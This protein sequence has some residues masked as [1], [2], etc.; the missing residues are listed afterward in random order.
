MQGGGGGGRPVYSGGIKFQALQ[1]H[2]KTAIYGILAYPLEMRP[3]SSQS[4]FPEG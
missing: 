2:L 1:N 4:P 3:E